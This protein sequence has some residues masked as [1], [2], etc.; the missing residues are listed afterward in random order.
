MRNSAGTTL[1]LLIGLATPALAEGPPGPDP[2]PGPLRAMLQGTSGPTPFQNEPVLPGQ[3]R[4]PDAVGE[5][6]KVLSTAR[7]FGQNWAEFRIGGYLWYAVV[8]Q[9]DAKSSQKDLRAGR[10]RGYIRW[11]NVTTR[12]FL[13]DFDLDRG[14]TPILNPEAML[15]LGPSVFRLSWWMWQEKSPGAITLPEIVA[16]GDRTY[17]GPGEPGGP[18]RINGELTLM[19]TKFIYEYRLYAVANLQIFVGL[20][21]HHLRYQAEFNYLDPIIGWDKNGCPIGAGDP[22]NDGI[23]NDSTAGP[24]NPR[25]DPE[26]HKPWGDYGIATISVRL[27]YRPFEGVYVTW[28]SQAMYIANLPIAGGHVSYGYADLKI[29]VWAAFSKWV[30]VGAGAR[31]WYLWTRLEGVGR[32]ETDFEGRVEIQGVFAGLFIKL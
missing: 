19:D 21:L 15:R 32:H 28:D 6:E 23:C 29:G 27:E 2:D 22:E 26:K 13:D 25:K 17:L 4:P 30:R 14:P 7:E 12:D 20:S 11:T 31:Y 10:A 1:A 5:F 3:I 18:T 9:M 16:F 24:I 8:K